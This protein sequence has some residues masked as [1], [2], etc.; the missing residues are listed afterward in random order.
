MLRSVRVWP[1][2]ETIDR[3]YATTDRPKYYLLNDPLTMAPPISVRAERTYKVPLVLEAKRGQWQ[4]L[5][6]K[7]EKIT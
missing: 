4:P 2:C 6:D 1:A 5:L 7:G 3:D